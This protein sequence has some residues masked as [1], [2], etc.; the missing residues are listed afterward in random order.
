VV[1][2]TAE[3]SDWDK[4]LMLHW[5]GSHWR[6]FARQATGGHDSAWLSAVGAAS[7]DDVWAGGGE[8]AEEMSPP[9]IGPLLL[10]W[11]GSRWAYASL[12]NSGET[13]FE[14]VAS[15][16]TGEAWAVS[17]NS[18]SYY[19]QG[20]FGFGTWRRQS[21]RWHAA[22]LPLGWELYGIAAAPARAGATRVVWAVGQVGTHIEDY[23]TRTV[24]LIR[25]F[26]C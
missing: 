19:E 4:A 5:D 1:G 6:S 22:E 2:N 26:G 24:P 17:A 23:A 16:A 3:P 8:H 10:H 11:D 15:T 7:S 12:P 21:G 25:R 13:E 18:W 20:S 9:A 14:A